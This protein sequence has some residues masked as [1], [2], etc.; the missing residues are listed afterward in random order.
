MIFSGE[1]ETIFNARRLANTALKY[2]NKVSVFM[3]RQTVDYEVISNS[4]LNLN[5]KVATLLR[6]RQLLCLRGGC[7]TSQ[8]RLVVL[9]VL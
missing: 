1:A 7:L 5:V 3:L 4:Q 6:T 8:G 9:W 2:N